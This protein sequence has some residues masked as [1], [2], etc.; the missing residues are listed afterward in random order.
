M[1][2]KLKVNVLVSK[3]AFDSQAGERAWRF[4]RAALAAGH[5][6]EQVFF[7]ESAVHQGSKL[8]EPLADEFDALKAWQTLSAEFGVTLVVCVSAAEKR[9]VLNSEM[10][11]QLQ[12]EA[13]NLDSVFEV[14]GLA[15]LHT[16]SLEADRTVNFQ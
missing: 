12:R 13:S 8:T 7:Y 5:R 2:K 6:V 15:S 11:E 9:G 3:A 4:C 14:R 1:S 16:A 10:A